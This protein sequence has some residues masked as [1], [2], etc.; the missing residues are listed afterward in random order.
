MAKTKTILKGPPSKKEIK[1]LERRWLYLFKQQR[2]KVP[3]RR[4]NRLQAQP[5]R[6]T[7]QICT[8]VPE[9]GWWNP[10]RCGHQFCNDCLTKIMWQDHDS[11]VMLCPVCRIRFYGISKN[12]IYQDDPMP[13]THL[14]LI[15]GHD[16]NPKSLFDKFH[17]HLY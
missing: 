11:E 12:P 17:R 16:M 2:N 13:L 14:K 8:L 9:D 10:D 5:G 3:P 7:C 4:S 15:P 6:R 1:F